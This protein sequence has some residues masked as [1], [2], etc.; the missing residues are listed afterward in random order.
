MKNESAQNCKTVNFTVLLQCCKCRTGVRCRKRM[1]MSNTLSY[2]LFFYR[3]AEHCTSGGIT[4]SSIDVVRFRAS[5]SALNKVLSAIW[6]QGILYRIFNIFLLRY[7]LKHVSEYYLT[8]R[9][10]NFFW[11]TTTPV[12]VDWFAGRKRKNNNN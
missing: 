3:Q 10:P 12:I 7:R 2:R 5:I 9:S 1:Q 8:H 11:Q 6:G 4:L